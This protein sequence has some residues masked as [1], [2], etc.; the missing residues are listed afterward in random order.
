MPWRFGE[1]VQAASLEPNGT[2]APF[3]PGMKRWFRKARNPYA[4]TKLTTILGSKFGYR[5]DTDRRSAAAEFPR[6]PAD[7]GM[8]GLEPGAR[9]SRLSC[10]VAAEQ[11]CH[12]H[13]VGRVPGFDGSRR[14]GVTRRA[15]SKRR[16]HCRSIDH[17]PSRILER[18]VV[19]DVELVTPGDI[20]TSRDVYKEGFEKCAA[21]I[22]AIRTHAQARAAVR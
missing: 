3:L 1:A 18:C 5:N 12:S 10:G 2:G 8:P 19:K 15:N 4:T 6:V 21:K 13:V 17:G 14:P 9:E 7:C 16:R 11:I 22:N 20:A